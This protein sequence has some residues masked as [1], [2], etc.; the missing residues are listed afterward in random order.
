MQRLRM[1]IYI[2]GCVPHYIYL[3]KSTYTYTRCL[4]SLFAFSNFGARKVSDI[5]KRELVSF[6]RHLR[7]NFLH[8]ISVFQILCC[9][10]TTDSLN[11]CKMA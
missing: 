4:Q 10:K 6:D 2:Y 5:Y 11:S 8:N 9:W 1:Y 7:N 3:S